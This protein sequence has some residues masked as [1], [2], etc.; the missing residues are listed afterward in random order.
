MTYNEITEIMCK[1]HDPR[2]LALEKASAYEEYIVQKLQEITAEVARI[3][4]NMRST[5]ICELDDVH[6]FV[7][8]YCFPSYAG[9]YTGDNNTVINFGYGGN[10]MD[11]AQA[12]TTIFSLYAVAYGEEDSN[13]AN[14]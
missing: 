9:D 14:E 7:R 13:N 11:I 12:I 6:D 2:K 5:Q 10:D 8:K 4:G 3:C 1:V